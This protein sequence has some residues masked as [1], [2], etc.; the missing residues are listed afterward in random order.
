M[1]DREKMIEMLMDSPGLV[2]L[3]DD[4]GRDA[5]YLLANGVTVQKWIPVTERLP[6]R[7]GSYIVCTDNGAVCTARYYYDL[8]MGLRYEEPH[9][10]S[11]RMQRH[12]TH[13]M[14]MPKSPV[15]EIKEYVESCEECGFCEMDG[16]A[17]N[18]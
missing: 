18:V 13:W 12:I 10:N 5:D 1:T 9:W 15:C 11:R 4:W 6:E 16:G 14:E 3:H 2:A 8:P 7:T 17:E